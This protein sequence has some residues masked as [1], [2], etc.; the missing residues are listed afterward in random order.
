MEASLKR[1]LKCGGQAIT[2]NEWVLR[3]RGTFSLRGE[4]RAFTR[5]K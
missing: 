1:Q 5:S 3:S 4:A 2:Q